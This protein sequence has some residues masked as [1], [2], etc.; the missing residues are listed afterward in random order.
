MAVIT[1][2]RLQAVKRLYIPTFLPHLCTS[3]PGGEW[4]MG[5]S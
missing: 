4:C 1:S 3:S 5:I 2:M